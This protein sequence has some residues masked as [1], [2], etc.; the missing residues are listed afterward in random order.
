MET[1][2]G[3]S[4]VPRESTEAVSPG[5]QALG[6]DQAVVV[7]RTEGAAVAGLKAFLIASQ[8]QAQQMRGPE[9]I[10]GV[11][12]EVARQIKIQ[13][14]LGEQ[15]EDEAVELL[16]HTARHQHEVG[17]RAGEIVEAELKQWCEDVLKEDNTDWRAYA[18]HGRRREKWLKPKIPAPKPCKR[19]RKNTRKMEEQLQDLLQP[20]LAACMRQEV[21]G[22]NADLDVNATASAGTN[23]TSSTHSNSNNAVTSAGGELKR[24]RGDGTPGCDTD[25]GASTNTTANT[26][27][28]KGKGAA[29]SNTRSNGNEGLD[30]TGAS[31]GGER[32]Q[33]RNIPGLTQL[34]AVITKCA[35][36]LKRLHVYLQAWTRAVASASIGEGA[37]GHKGN[38]AADERGPS[39]PA[40]ASAHGIDIS[41]PSAGELKDQ[42]SWRIATGL[43]L[44]VALITHAA[45]GPPPPPKT[46]PATYRI[47]AQ[48]GGAR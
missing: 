24:K 14:S 18:M 38:G 9:V 45:Y 13:K 39:R 31:G 3:P 22:V 10:K 48:R 8:E 46:Q 28:C 37:C 17:D 32:E 47:H 41:E 40:Q 25:L 12:A 1:G 2:R 6:R 21:W 36:A 15:S 35:Q 7:V 33:S 30:S 19:R 23:G 26:A 29:R 4:P 42:Q 27:I 44:W 43:A 20:V 34:W 16:I 5:T 11:V